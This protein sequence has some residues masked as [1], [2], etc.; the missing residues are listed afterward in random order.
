MAS[1]DFTN[2]LVARRTSGKPWQIS[3]YVDLVVVSS[4][5]IYLMVASSTGA[6]LVGGLVKLCRFA[7]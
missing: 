2:L 4:N 6:N 5:C 7:A 1:F 3:D